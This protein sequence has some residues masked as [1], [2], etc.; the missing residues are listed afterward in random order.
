MLLLAALLLPPVVQSPFGRTPGWEQSAAMYESRIGNGMEYAPNQQESNLGTGENKSSEIW[1]AAKQAEL[2]DFAETGAEVGENPAKGV[3][4][5]TGGGQG[6][7]TAEGT[8]V[9]AETGTM[10]GGF[11]LWIGKLFPVLWAAGTVLIL[12]YYF[13]LL[14]RLK[15]RVREAVRSEGN[16]WESAETSLPFV[17]PGFPCRIYIPVG[18]EESR[19]Q[20]ILAHEKQHIRH[21]DPWVKLAAVLALALHWYNPFVWAAVRLLDKDMEMFCDETVLKHKNLEE[22][23]H[24]SE[25]LLAFSAQDSGLTVALSFG[26]SNTENRI[27]H[28]LYSQKPKWFVSILLVAAILG[29]ALLFLTIREEK[30][31]ET[32]SLVNDKSVMESS[33]GTVPDGEEE[34]LSSTENIL[35]G[36]PEGWGYG[37]QEAAQGENSYTKAI[38]EQG[39]VGEAKDA[40]TFENDYEKDGFEAAFVVMGEEAEGVMSGSLWFVNGDGRTL[41][42]EQNVEMSSREMEYL[43]RGDDRYLFLSYQKENLPQSRIL[44]Y[45]DTTPEELLEGIPGRKEMGED[46]IILCWLSAVDSGFTIMPDSHVEST[47]VANTNATNTNAVE[48]NQADMNQAQVVWTGRTEKPYR[49]RMEEDGKIREISA[50]IITGEKVAAYPFGMSII[51]SVEAAYPEG[52]KQYILR[53]NG[54]LNVNIA[55]ER[56]QEADFYYMT[57][58]VEGDSWQ[59]SELS[60]MTDHGNGVYR[61]AMT[62]EE[63]LKLFLNAFAG[64]GHLLPNDMLLLPWMQNGES[65]SG[66]NV[67]WEPLLTENWFDKRIVGDSFVPEG[68][69]ATRL[70]GIFC[71]MEPTLRI[72]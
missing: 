40:W 51:E 35:A 19:K 37:L 5:W 17:M 68:D 26:E 16:V 25:T 34:A 52:T 4:D 57:F 14:L 64:E 27:R 15:K 11:W 9:G 3:T 31:L 30:P 39:A 23:K 46:G 33:S 18:I 62:G 69:L 45:E 13:F 7:G 29:C 36:L 28:I 21:G 43:D 24:Y 12:V 65:G 50:Q 71:S 42:L 66:E 10:S 2:A 61:K 59:E 56:E 1:L 20:D 8:V 32:E 38:R 22:K 49:F 70:Q 72:I 48:A 44:K 53:E 60:L 47:T 63:S 54:E 55:M 41:L 58:Q 6:A 67:M